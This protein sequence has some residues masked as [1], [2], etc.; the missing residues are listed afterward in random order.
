MGEWLC[1]LEPC[2]DRAFSQ[3]ATVKIWKPPETQQ[4]TG[5]SENASDSQV[6]I[7]LAASAHDFWGGQ[8][9]DT[10]SRED[11]I[12]QLFRAASEHHGGK[13][14]K[15]HLRGYCG[16]DISGGVTDFLSSL[17]GD[18]LGHAQFVEAAG[19]LMPEDQQ[20]YVKKAR[21]VLDQIQEESELQ[22]M[23]EPWMLLRHSAAV[24]AVG[25]GFAFDPEPPA[26]GFDTTSVSQ[27]E[28]E[29]GVPEGIGDLT[30]EE[31]EMT[32]NPRRPAPPAQPTK[33][34]GPDASLVMVT[35]TIDGAVK[36]WHINETHEAKR[37]TGMIFLFVEAD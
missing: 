12:E 33:K 18:F 36:L 37:L 26:V 35:G 21:K 17:D 13:V 2:A 31:L 10:A 19:R 6:G 5:V 3:D 24:T 8:V 9:S 30:L 34:L 16:G 7:A 32:E 23:M 28:T 22:I 1:I 20:T 14:P 4:T 11:V 25:V 29:P 15:G 27:A